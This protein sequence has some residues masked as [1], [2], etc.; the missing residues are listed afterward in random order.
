MTVDESRP[1]VGHRALRRD[2]V[3]AEHDDDAGSAEA[4]EAMHLEAMA[5]M[6]AEQPWRFGPQEPTETLDRR[7]HGRLEEER[8]EQ[9]IWPEGAP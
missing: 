3:Q 4:E 9:A 7:L 8:F 6:R 5:R 1:W 2:H